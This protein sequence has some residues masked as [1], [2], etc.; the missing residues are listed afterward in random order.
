MRLQGKMGSLRG[1]G[2]IQSGDINVFGGL[3]RYQEFS[4]VRY[5]LVLVF[6]EGSSP[7]GHYI[8][9]VENPCI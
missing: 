7:F 9:E 5:R 2:E 1:F 6:N 4:P 8:L 3:A